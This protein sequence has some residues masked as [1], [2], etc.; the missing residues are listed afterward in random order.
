MEEFESLQ[1]LL[2]TGLTELGQLWTEIGVEDDARDDRKFKNII[3]RMLEEETGHKAKLLDHLET[4]SLICNK[5][6]KE[7]GVSFEEPDPNMSLLKLQHAVRA[8]VRK[9]EEMKKANI[10]QFIINLRNELNEIWDQCF[11]SEDQKNSFQALHSID[12]T[13]ELLEQHE[14]ELERMKEYLEL[15]KELFIKV[16]K[17]QD[18]W[19]KFMEL[20]RKAKDPSRLMNARGTALLE[21]EKERNR[22]NKTLP[23][24]EQEL[25]EL[26]QQWEQDHGRDFRVRGVSFAAFIDDQKE[27]HIRGLEMEKMAREKAK[28]ENLLHET[29]YGAK[30]STPAKLKCTLLW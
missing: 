2:N 19:N 21:E 11:Y 22:V 18:I 5:L 30:P 6:S 15:N 1:T 12:F 25:H 13:E 27:E 3:D 29:R 26:I 7:L 9:L 28:K 20:E 23:R 14:A 8:E 24:V 4:Y 16:E 17:Y 10:E